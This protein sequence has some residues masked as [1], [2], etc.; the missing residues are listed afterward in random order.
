M[1]PMR[2]KGFKC[3]KTQVKQST[4]NNFIYFMRWFTIINM[5]SAQRGSF[6]ALACP[7]LVLLEYNPEDL[8]HVKT[9]NLEDL[10]WKTHIRTILEFGNHV[11]LLIST[12]IYANK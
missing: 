2:S 6:S 12:L 8:I 9:R 3:L 7:F 11:S 1:E 4:A 10:F 5:F